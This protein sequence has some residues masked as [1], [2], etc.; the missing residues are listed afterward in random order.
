MH[1]LMN[2]SFQVEGSLEQVHMSVTKSMGFQT[3]NPET[4]RELVQSILTQ[5]ATASR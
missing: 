1:A 2:Q 5:P 3:T 4:E